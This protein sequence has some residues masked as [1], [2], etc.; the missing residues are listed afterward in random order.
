MFRVLLA[1]VDVQNLDQ[2]GGD[3]GVILQ[4]WIVEYVLQ[5]AQDIVFP[6]VSDCKASVLDSAEFREALVEVVPMLSLHISGHRSA[7]ESF[8]VIAKFL[9]SDVAIDCSKHCPVSS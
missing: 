2:Y 4:A 9:K 1:W 8:Y 7:P 5:V 6:D 3:C